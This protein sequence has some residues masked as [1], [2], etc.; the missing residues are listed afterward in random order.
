PATAGTAEETL[1]A[2]NGL[3]RATV[4]NRGGG[5]TSFVLLQHTDEKK[6]PLEL[7][8]QLPPPPPKTPGLEVPG[9]PKLTQTIAQALFVI[10]KEGDKTLRLKYADDQVAVTKEVRL[11]SG[12]LFHVKV[13]VI[14]PPYVLMAGTGLRNPTEDELSSRY[15]T[16]AAALARTGGGFAR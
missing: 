8:R 14:G 1:K 16:P 6:Q 12:Y 2:E 4:S 10:E 11:E 9:K 5:I 3:V 13:K 7:L 15:F